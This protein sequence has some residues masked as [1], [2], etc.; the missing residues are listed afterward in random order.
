MTFQKADTEQVSE[1][2]LATLRQNGRVVIESGT[3]LVFS[4]H[5]RQSF[6]GAATRARDEIAYRANNYRGDES[7]PA[8]AK[9]GAEDAKHAIETLEVAIKDLRGIYERLTQSDRFEA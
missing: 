6:Q 8:N 2:D 7:L 5:L 4:D 1:T 9:D 3:V